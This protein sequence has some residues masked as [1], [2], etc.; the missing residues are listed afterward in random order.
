MQANSKGTVMPTV[1]ASSG[2]E[3]W[4]DRSRR[5]R[6]LFIV[7]PAAFVGFVLASLALNALIGFSPGALWAIAFTWFVSMRQLRSNVV[8]LWLRKFRPDDRSR[9]PFGQLLGNVCFGMASP[10]T[11]QDA[12]YKSSYLDSMS[13]L[14]WLYPMAIGGLLLFTLGGTFLILVPAAGVL[15][16]IPTTALV[17]LVTVIALALAAT[18][19]VGVKRMLVRRGYVLLRGNAGEARARR[20]LSEIQAGRRSTMGGVRVLSCDEAIWQDV[21]KE[22][23]HR[24]HAVVIDITDWTPNLE[25]EF[26]QA[27]EHLAAETILLVHAS[28]GESTSSPAVTQFLSAFGP[29]ALARHPQFAYPVSNPGIGRDRALLLKALSNDLGPLIANCLGAARGHAEPLRAKS[30]EPQRSLSV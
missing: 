18:Y 23:L 4:A 22:A 7:A 16:T 29:D 20:E 17:S 25:W 30:S 14:I 2:G 26:R 19:V 1:F 27:R 9:F 8:V 24:A 11:I 3:I 12:S 10:I 15:D 13:R 28:D 5:H 6:R 21:V